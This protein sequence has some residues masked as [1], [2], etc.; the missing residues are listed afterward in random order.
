M[1]GYF[2]W[3]AGALRRIPGAGGRKRDKSRKQMER[4]SRRVNR[5][6]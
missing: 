3:L 5:K 6:K 2:G 4:A 1:G